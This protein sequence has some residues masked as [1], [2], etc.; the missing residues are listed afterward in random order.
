MPSRWRR[1]LLSALLGVALAGTLS[2]SAAAQEVAPSEPLQIIANSPKAK[3]PGFRVSAGE[4]VRIAVRVPEV[5]AALAE[6]DL[7]RLVAVPGYTGDPYRWQVTY[8]RDGTGVVEVHV[9][10]RSGQVLEVWTG[11][12]VD[13][14]LARPW[15]DKTGGLLN[16]AWIWIPLCLLFLAPF[17]DPRRPLRLL[18]L[19]LLVLLSFGIAQLL[20]NEGNLDVWVPA[21]YPVLG[22]LLVRLLLAGF[23]PRERRERLVPFASESWLLAGLVLL[24]AGRI[25]LNIVDSNVIDV[26]YQ[27]V[28]GADNLLHGGDISG[29]GPVTFLAYVPFELIFP[30]QGAWDALPAAHAAA[31]T[32]DLLTVLGL[33][34]LGRSLRSGREGRLLGVALAYAWVAFPYSTYVLQSNT[35]DGLVAMLL[36]YAMLAL[37]S[38]T[39]SGLVLGLATAAKFFPAALAP[40]LAVGTGDRRPRSLLRFAGAFAAVGLIAAYVVLP[41]GGVRELWHDTI[42]YQLGR[43]SPFSMWGLHP[44]LGW[45]QLLVELGTGALCI[46]LAFVPGRRDA[47][48]VAALAAA[49]VI[50][51]QLCATYWLFFYVAWFAPLA[52]VAML[53]AYRPPLPPS[54][55][56][57]EGDLARVRQA[58]APSRRY[59]TA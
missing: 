12:Q 57:P 37:R 5:R 45:L 28:V 31:I 39:G 41:D 59:T 52:L 1:A 34:L 21:V 40:L 55:V 4:A 13:F 36:V 58:S 17:V 9:D 43:E 54:R 48:Q 6:G 27:S 47:R 19:D 33:V 2:P 16:E 44:S 20:F 50:A 15:K 42:G 18:H 49:V 29:Y 14:L 24:V 53:A 8:S 26:G 51:L 38:P 56:P 10:G 3:P 46:A 23:R 32:F 22:Y 35:N 7:D 30:W 11:P 25:V